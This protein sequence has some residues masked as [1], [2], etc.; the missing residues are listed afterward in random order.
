MIPWPEVSRRLARLAQGTRPGTVL[1]LTLPLAALPTGLPL[2]GNWWH[3]QQPRAHLTLTG[4]GEVL[5]VETAG[6]GRFA[7]LGAATCG[8]IKTWRHDGEGAPPLAFSGFAFAADGGNPLAN[9]S[10]VVPALLLRRQGE[11]ACVTFSCT[12]AAASSAIGDWRT[13]WSKLAMRPA[14][15]PPGPFRRLQAPL[16]DLAF[17]ARG[18]A[19][20]RAIE[21]GEF[22]K[23]VLT[24]SIRLRA[25][26]PALAARVIAA[27]AAE[28]PACTTWAVGRGNRVF[29][30]ASPERLLRLGQ[31]RAEADAL[32]GTA[33]IADAAEGDSS[34]PLAGD[35]NRHEH[36][37]VA[38]SVAAALRPLCEGVV[39][40]EAPETLRLGKLQHLR[41]CIVG[42]VRPGVA[43]FDLI[44][45]L[46][47][48][49][50][51]GG[52]PTADAIDWLA[53]HG[54]RRSAWYTGGIGWLGA[55]G[56]ADFA[57]ALRCGL[58][59]GREATLF[60]GAGFVA[61]SEPRQELAET[62]AKFAA[63]LSALRSGA[64]ADEDVAWTGT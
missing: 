7:A 36:E 12:A 16:A 1:S 6:H 13:I 57:V 45:R 14:P 42:Q 47:P 32:A 23:L 44:A 62:E 56:S 58:I 30:G 52:S 29:L 17:L 3:W 60:A 48:T 49:P 55:D 40:P 22:A 21:A 9:A 51:V 28:N 33:W 2:Q 15:P 20:L 35:K 8:L 59:A 43:A 46:H 41:R 37:L 61:G 63:M 54:D 4:I 53:R 27:L 19:A 64:K 5:G 26:R 38:A 10:L 25:D 50:A 18:Q 39:V 24:R 34:L 31:G 11:A